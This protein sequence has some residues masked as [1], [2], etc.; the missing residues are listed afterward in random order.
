VP[1]GLDNTEYENF[2]GFGNRSLKLEKG[3]GFVRYGTLK[4]LSINFR[5]FF[6]SLAVELEWSLGI[7][8]CEKY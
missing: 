3:N 4:E 7:N 8:L 2:N 1:T 5:I 6:R